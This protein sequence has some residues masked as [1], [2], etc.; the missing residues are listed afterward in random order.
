MHD[1][2]IINCVII[3]TQKTVV[4]ENARVLNVKMKSMTVAVCFRQVSSLFSNQH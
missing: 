2:F 4:P 3:P 1:Q